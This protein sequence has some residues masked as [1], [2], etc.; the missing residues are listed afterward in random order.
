MAR[1]AHVL[2]LT[3][4]VFLLGNNLFAATG[5]TC[6]ASVPSGITSCFYA[7]YANGS[8]A[9]AG[10]SESAPL[11]HFP[12]MT[13]CTKN[14]SSITP[15]AGEGFILRGGIT[16]TSASLPWTW[17]WSGT[18]T[19]S[20]P[21]CTGSGCIYVGVDQTWYT[22]SSWARPILNGGGSSGNA[23]KPILSLQGTA[24]DLVFDNLEL[25]GFYWS[26]SPSYGTASLSLP[27]GT[28][29][30]GTNDTFE[31]LYIHGWSHSTASGT[32][33]DACGVTGDTSDVNNNA[34]SILEYSVISGADTTED[35]CALDF[36]GPAYIAYNWMEYGSSCMV[37]DGVVSVHDNVCQYVVTSW[38]GAHENGLEIN[39]DAQNHTVYN[40]VIR[41]LGGG[42]LG[43]W[44]QPK[45]GYTAYVF[46]NLIYDTQQ[47]NVIDL[48]SQSEYYSGQAGKD[49]L[50]NNTVE[51]GTDPT[52]DAVCADGI[53]S[54]VTAVT[55]Q[56]N[57]FIT[58]AGSYWGTSGP[59]PTT[60][61]NLLQTY[62][63]ASG[64]G[65]T[66]SETY[67]FSPTASSNST[68]GKGTSASSLCSAAGVSA[69]VCNNDTTYGVAYNATNHTVTSPGRTT[70]PWKSPP[71]IGAYSYGTGPGTPQNLTGSAVPQ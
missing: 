38:A 59:T 47:N 11:Q 15:A 62:S 36:G 4:C 32:E 28:P 29:G 61:T 7:D 41:H 8:D 35:A 34:N 54:G 30:D 31:H 20:S 58:N 12:G 2:L 64:Q 19:T 44:D 71:D 67:A 56:N 24:S 9:N 43:F 16:W 57:H 27:G 10:T 37:V 25:T 70:V 50:W 3:G 53:G 46:N 39:W 40:N 55:L 5:G 22:G 14:C 6:P 1:P 26:G 66:A 45:P 18:S 68:V 60:T 13:G 63:T 23:N 48:A 65:Y 52:P 33:D 17:T 69:T 49:I 21:G 51:C 42:T